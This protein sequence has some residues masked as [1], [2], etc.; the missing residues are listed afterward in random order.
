M[1]SRSF[2]LIFR[3]DNDLFFQTCSFVTF[4]F[5]SN[6]FHYTF[7]F[8]LTGN[9]R[10]DNGIERVPFDDYVTLSN[11]ISVVKEQLRTVRDIM[12]Q[13][14]DLCIRIDD[15]HFSQTAYYYL[16]FLTSCSVVS[17][18]STKF[19]YFQ[20]TVVFRCNA[21]FCSNVRSNTTDMECTQCQLCTRLT[22]R[23]GSDN[24]DNFTFLNHAA[25]CQVTTVTLST[26]TFL[27]FTG[28]Y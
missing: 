3:F 26:N 18:N 4:H 13:Q 15:T 19:V 2:C 5:V 24:S 6:T 21:V 22:D 1:S 10:Y 20:N 17:F 23:L 11:F 12:S 7:E 9:F 25:C 16:I 28:K 27:R 14:Y 8:D